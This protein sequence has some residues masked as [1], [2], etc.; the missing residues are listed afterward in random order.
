MF[1]SNKKNNNNFGKIETLISQDTE[2]EGFI[3]AT[4]TLRI[5]G[6]VKGGIRQADG[7]I[8]GQSG[9]VNGDIH[10]TGI[11]I[12]GKVEG[13]II[14]ETKLELLPDSTVIGDIEAVDLSISEGAT[15]NGNCTMKSQQ[16]SQPE[17]S[18]K[19]KKAGLTKKKLAT[20]QPT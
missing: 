19:K 3:D 11:S 20:E 13:N 15:F 17:K 4:G 7:L 14:S 12:S 1:G 5:D 16:N 8:L 9:V 6:T 18:E 10:S 2:I